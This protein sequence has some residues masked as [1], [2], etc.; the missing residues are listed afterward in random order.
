MNSFKLTPFWNCTLLRAMTNSLKN[1]LHIL[2]LYTVYQCLAIVVIRKN[3]ALAGT[4]GISLEVG[5]TIARGRIE[6]KPVDAILEYLSSTPYYRHNR[7][8]FDGKVIDLHR[9]TAK[10]FSVG[11]CTIAALES[12]DDTLHI[13]FQNEYLVARHNGK[14]KAIVPDLICMVD[15]E[16]AEPIP[17][18]ALRYGQRVKVI[19]ASVA[20]IMRTPEALAVVGPAAFSIDEDFIPIEDIE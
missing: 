1:Q 7:I 5:R 19:G 2:L 16:T 20:P 12:L 13:E 10:G 18:E 11:Q 3:Y 6:G 15:R 8:L 17:V 4:L 14:V 9:E